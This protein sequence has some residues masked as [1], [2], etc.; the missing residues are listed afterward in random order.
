MNRFEAT[1]LL[2][3]KMS[4]GDLFPVPVVALTAYASNKVEE[5]CHIAGMDDICK[6]YTYIYI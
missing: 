6:L 5:E 4:A 1:S 2:K 3:V